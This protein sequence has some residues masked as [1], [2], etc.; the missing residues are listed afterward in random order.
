MQDA[1]KFILFPTVSN[2]VYGEAVASNVDAIIHKISD[3]YKINAAALFLPKSEYDEYNNSSFDG[4][5]IIKFCDLVKKKK[6]VDML[7]TPRGFEKAAH[8]SLSKVNF[9]IGGK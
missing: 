7:N 9:S 3:E 5:P 1:Q 6:F 8:F 4:K 2:K